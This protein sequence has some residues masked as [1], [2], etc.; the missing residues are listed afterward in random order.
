MGA[1]ST[2]AWEW[3]ALVLC[4]QGCASRAV[5]AQMILV[6]RLA[7]S[8]RMR[9]WEHAELSDYENTLLEEEDDGN[10]RVLEHFPFL[11]SAH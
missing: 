3:W 5:R 2:A 4:E 8:P 10:C 7:L 9:R 1:D 6:D 11:L